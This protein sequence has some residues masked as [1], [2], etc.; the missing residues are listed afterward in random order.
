MKRPKPLTP[1][2]CATAVL[3]K[4]Q[5]YLPPTS[6]FEKSAVQSLDGSTL[7]KLES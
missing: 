5:P 2:V 4:E 1:V 6:A 3:P 7:V